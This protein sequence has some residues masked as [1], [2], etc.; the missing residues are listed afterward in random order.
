[1]IGNDTIIIVSNHQASAPVI[2]EHSISSLNH[3]LLLAV[4]GILLL[5]C[6]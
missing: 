4:I 6:S 1:M 5:G 2:K 3:C